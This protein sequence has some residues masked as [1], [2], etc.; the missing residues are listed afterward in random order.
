MLPNVLGKKTTI[1]SIIKYSYLLYLVSLLP[2][3][4][5]IIQELYILL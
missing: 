3:I 4:F 1:K 2:Y 5:L